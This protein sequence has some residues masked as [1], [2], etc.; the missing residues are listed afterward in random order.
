M[1]WENLFFPCLWSS[2]I[3]KEW[4]PLIKNVDMKTLIFGE[5]PCVD[6]LTNW[7]HGAPII[8][9]DLPSLLVLAHGGLANGE[10]ALQPAAFAALQTYPGVGKWT[11][12][13]LKKYY[14][15]RKKKVLRQA[16]REKEQIN[17]RFLSFFL[18]FFPGYCSAVQFV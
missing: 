17:V 11:K 2:L 5:T 10:A 12:F 4:G 1:Y 7:V 6:S 3:E 9:A 14:M 16:E 8:K 15:H 13:Y 18:Y